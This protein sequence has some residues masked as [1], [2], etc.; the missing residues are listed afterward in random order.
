MLRFAVFAVLLA[1][2][3]AVPISDDASSA[4]DVL[5]GDSIEEFLAENPEIEM[6]HQLE[7]VELHSQDGNFSSV[8]TFGKRV[9]GK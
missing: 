9:A 1:A 2:V 3:C 6:L 5:V 7:E 4:I 8:F